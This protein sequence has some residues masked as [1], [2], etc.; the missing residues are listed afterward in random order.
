MCIR[1]RVSTQSTGEVEGPMS[2]IPFL[3]LLVWLHDA[4]SVPRA[5]SPGCGLAPPVRTG[6]TTARSMVV[7]GHNRTYRLRVPS[8]YQRGV[9]L[10][11]IVSHHGWTCSAT[12]DEEASGLSVQAEQSGFVVA[13]LNGYDD[14]RHSAAF[15]WRSWNGAGTVYSN[16][17][18]PGCY[19]W[20]GTEQY[21]YESCSGRHGT[22]HDGGRFSGCDAIGCDWTT[23]VSSDAFNTAVLNLL[24]AELC[25]DV[26]RE[27]ATGQS[28]G[29]IYSFHLG[30]S[31]S[32]R[33]A[34]I[35]PI[36][37]SMMNGYIKPPALPIPVLDCTG[38]LDQT[39]PINDTTFGSGAVSNEGWIYETMTAIF[40]QWEP[41]N[42]CT[43]A[44][45]LEPWPTS[46]DGEQQ[47]YCWGRR[48]GARGEYPAIRCA[49]HGA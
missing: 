24:E 45:P 29:A 4:A 12:E 44:E 11:V 2:G 21:C 30:A 13:Y 19:S 41:A 3:L 33:F 7:D 39:V 17:T 6:A 34:A 18:K 14:N 47:L 27:Y 28:N 23:C 40:A 22:A 38:T 15:S 20:G 25:I 8:S 43:G 49:W 5:G 1:D 36:S 46:L 32:H 48:C 26:T 16:Q 37:G 31:M 42:G 9:P 35:V 10:P